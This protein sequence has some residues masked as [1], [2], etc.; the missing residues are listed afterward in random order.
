MSREGRGQGSS[1]VLKEAEIPITQLNKKGSEKLATND[2]S[3]AN[4][5][6]VAFRPPSYATRISGRRR[7]RVDLAE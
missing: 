5:P 6:C 2:H 4:Y 3:I 7:S 1:S